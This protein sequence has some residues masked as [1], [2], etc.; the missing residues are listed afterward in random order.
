M[1]DAITKDAMAMLKKLLTEPNEFKKYI[2]CQLWLQQ[3]F[4][5]TINEPLHDINTN[6]DTNINTV[7][8]DDDECG[9]IYNVC[10]Y[11]KK[12]LM[13]KNEQLKQGYS[14]MVSQLHIME[15]MNSIL[16]LDTIDELTEYKNNVAIV[17][18]IIAT[19]DEYISKI[20]NLSEAEIAKIIHHD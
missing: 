16:T 20:N 1:T 10:K 19:N 17:N 2:L 15:V 12:Q 11:I 18:N 14:K 6:T 3:L 13:N 8:N 7:G 4:T 5:S 9:H